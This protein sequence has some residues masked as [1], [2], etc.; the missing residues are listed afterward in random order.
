MKN[1]Q[2]YDTS[3]SRELQ[4]PHDRSRVWLPDNLHSLPL[5][6]GAKRIFVLSLAARGG[7][8]LSRLGQA[9][10]VRRST[11]SRWWGELVKAG[12][13]LP[14]ERG[15]GARAKPLK[16]SGG[17]GMFWVPSLWVSDPGI[18]EGEFS[19]LLSLCRHAD[20]RGRCFVSNSHLSS[21]C[22]LSERTVKRHLK[23][24]EEKGLV[25]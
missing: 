20:G 9:L 18:S 5:S 25:V 3:P 13:A 8:S 1:M 14:A 21:D 12:L 19:I 16:Q 11:A 24:L 17:G 10:G 6:P 2:Y 22:G 23:S 15:R 4:P 7:W